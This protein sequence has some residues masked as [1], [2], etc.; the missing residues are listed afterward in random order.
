[1]QEPKIINPIPSQA[2][3]ELAAFGPFDLTE[4]IQTPDDSGIQFQAELA[5]GTGLPKGLICL[6]DGFI[7]GIPA[8]GTQGNYEVII[9]ARNDAGTIETKFSIAILPVNA[10]Q[11][12][13]AYSDE[14]KRQIWQ[15]LDQNLPAPELEALLNQAVTPLD[16]YYLLERW[17][18]LT[19]YDAMNLSAPGN[20]VE[21]QLADAS[22]HYRTI[23]RGCCLV[24]CPKDL[25]SHERTLV[26]GIM[27]A[28]ALMREAYNR[29]WTVE[30]IGFEKL[31]RAAW[32]E[33]QHLGDK[34]QRKADIINY[35][36]TNTDMVLYQEQARAESLRKGI[37]T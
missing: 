21:L 6:E 25:F 5:D 22:P 30:L 14:L 23:D 35:E 12:T 33:A 20:L 15:A 32:V 1:M 37:N 26:D 28:Q 11:S 2:V 4:F 24:A 29:N 34:F 31:T 16:V 10:D 9:H 17:G 18:T 19:I 8:K 27:T 3:N 36:P 13:Q 7:T